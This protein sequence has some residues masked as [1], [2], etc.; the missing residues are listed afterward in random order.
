MEHPMEHVSA[1]HCCP[2]SS[3]YWWIRHFFC[4][5]PNPLFHHFHF[6][7]FFCHRKQNDPKIKSLET[8]ATKVANDSQ[9]PFLQFRLLRWGPNTTVHPKFR[10][11]AGFVT[12][13]NGC[14]VSPS[15]VPSPEKDG[16]R[17]NARKNVD[18]PGHSIS[19]WNQFELHQIR[20]LWATFIF[21]W[22]HADLWENFLDVIGNDAS[23]DRCLIRTIGQIF[24][25]QRSHDS[26]LFIHEWWIHSNG[27]KI[28]E[29]LVV[30]WFYIYVLRQ[31]K[32]FKNLLHDCLLL[33]TVPKITLEGPQKTTFFGTVWNNF[34]TN[35]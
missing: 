3:C 33:K 26:I 32:E 15:I 20:L 25:Q 10:C 22:T 30:V 6:V 19:V 21:A 35:V 17:S 24:K 9:L 1:S 31:T 16:E 8:P 27:P 12:I 14:A 29:R 13:T 2:S 23:G 7:F 28:H 34:Q 5:G 11:Q 18:T 4:T